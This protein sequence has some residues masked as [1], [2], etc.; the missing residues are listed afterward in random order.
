MNEND[1]EL[2]L[3]GARWYAWNLISNEGAILLHDHGRDDL[4]ETVGF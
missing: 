4:D 3:L 2:I 1:Y